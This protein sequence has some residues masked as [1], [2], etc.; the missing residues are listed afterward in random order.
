[1]SSANLVVTTGA[2]LRGVLVLLDRIPAP[3]WMADRPEA[4]R[5]LTD[6]L[7]WIR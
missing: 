7:T 5:Q 1:L 2:L 6:L 3:R 4:V